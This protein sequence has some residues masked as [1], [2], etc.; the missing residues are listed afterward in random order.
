[1]TLSNGT[2]SLCT[3]RPIEEFEMP[4]VEIDERTAMAVNLAAE[5]AGVTP[6]EVIRR[7]VERS[8]PAGAGAQSPEVASLARVAVHA[9]YDGHRTAAVYD[10]A[11]HRVTNSRPDVNPNRNGWSF[12]TVTTTGRLLQTLRDS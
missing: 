6:G 1:L 11:T 2:S 10:Q 3:I 9:V 12:W 4:V 8:R 7:L 5:M